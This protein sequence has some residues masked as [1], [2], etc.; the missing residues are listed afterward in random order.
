[1][2][3][4][5][6]ASTRKTPSTWRWWLLGLAVT[7]LAIFSP[8]FSSSSTP[9]CPQAP[10]HNTQSQ[11]QLTID[12]L[13]NL[14]SEG[15]REKSIRR[16]KGAI[17]IQTVAYDDMGPVDQDPRWKVF[18]DFADYLHTVF[19]SL[20]GRLKLEKVNR[21]GLLYT[22][23]G[24]D[25]SLKPTVLMAHQDVVPVPESTISQWNYAPFSGEFD[26]SSIWGRGALDCKNTLIASLEAVE[27]L[28]AAGF[29][30][31][32]TIILSFGFDEEISG[33]YGASFLASYLL[34]RYGENG[35]SLIIDEGAPI[36]PLWGTHFAVP[37]VSEKGY[38]DVQIV[39]RTKGGH[40]SMPPAH[41]SAG[42][43]AELVNLI[44]KTP[45]PPQLHQDNPLL[46]FLWC[47]AEHA[48]SFMP[49]LKYLLPKRDSAG[50]FET[51]KRLLFPRIVARVNHM[52]GYLIST[53]QAVDVVHGG[54]KVNALP[55]RT[56]V[57]INHRVNIGETSE[58]IR[59]KL[60]K[61][62]GMVAKR[63]NL[64]LH[65]FDGSEEQQSSIN[66]RFMG[67]VLEPAPV[68]PIYADDKGKD[69]P[70]SVISSTTRALYGKKVVMAPGIMPANTD[71]KYYWKLSRHIFR[72]SPGWDP[73]VLSIEGIHTINERVSIIA[74][75]RTVQW[76]VSFLRRADEAKFS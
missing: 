37:G 2:A 23:T 6:Q 67:S 56:T 33:H 63:H 21:H 3:A 7:A 51:A 30:P 4:L 42:I 43:A 9:L 19:P 73:K 46:D 15:Y 62:T 52:A 69:T 55:E 25:S 38:V 18:D 28:L 10:T 66:I 11:D 58:L 20:H 72:Y 57:L 17:Q 60:T 36:L 40:S 34:Q 24:S 70:W 44:E 26:G 53:T 65:A 13:R 59:K 31:R 45:Y 22:W 61:L 50:V 8:T 49:G 75:I 64:T 76:Y 16:L 68:T 35:V 41:T 54:V 48:P 5:P 47:G 32:R 27:T 74:H 14:S 39:V 12:M 71:T 29:E 1:M